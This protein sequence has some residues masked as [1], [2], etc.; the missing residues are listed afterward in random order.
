MKVKWDNSSSDCCC[1]SLLLFSWF[2]RVPQAVYT[3]SLHVSSKVITLT[4]SVH[5]SRTVTGVY[6][7][8]HVKRCV[9]ACPCLAA[10]TD[11]GPGFDSTSPAK[12]RF[13]FARHRTETWLEKQK[14]RWELLTRHVV[15]IQFASFWRMLIRLR[16]SCIVRIKKV[17]SFFSH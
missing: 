13:R 3:L 8:V 15:L 11:V 6:S 10:H 12:S 5:R 16:K 4:G 7:S 9:V 14:R 2:W 1:C 17:D